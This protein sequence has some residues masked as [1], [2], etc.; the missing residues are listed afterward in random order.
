MIHATGGEDGL[1]DRLAL[2]P[3]GGQADDP[4]RLLGVEEPVLVVVAAELGLD[5]STSVRFG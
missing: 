5:L 2:A 4:V 3:R 1:Q